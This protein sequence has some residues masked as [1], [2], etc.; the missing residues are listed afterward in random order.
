M[1]TRLNILFNRNITIIISLIIVTVIIFYT[2]INMLFDLNKKETM[3]S[4]LMPNQV[5]RQIELEDYLVG[6]LAAEMPAEFEQEAL[7]AQALAARTYVL[8]RKEDNHTVSQYDVDTTEK[9]QA[10]CSKWDM[11]R[12]WGFVKYWQYQEK[13]TKAVQDTKGKVIVYKDTKIEAL[14]FSSCGRKATENSEDVWGNKINY[15][16]SVSSQENNPLRFVQKQEYDSTT[17]FQLLGIKSTNNLSKNTIAIIERTGAGRIKQLTVQGKIFDSKDFRA[18][19]KLNSTD[20]EWAINSNKIIFTVYGKGHA[21]GMSQY[22]A[23]DM[24]KAGKS[25]EEIIK[26]YYKNSEIYQS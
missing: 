18:K 23:N 4:V 6:V 24:A 1:R 21:V 10:W 13:L 15:L 11:I 14:F 9:T 22:G 5:V 8:K 20:F 16:S 19:L 3:I 12:K 17:F 25:F 26:Y 2:A 7:K